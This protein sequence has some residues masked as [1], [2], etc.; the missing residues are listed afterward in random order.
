M[1]NSSSNY[2]LKKKTNP[3]FEF[4]LVIELEHEPLELVL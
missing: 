2:Q 3:E 4:V 1:G